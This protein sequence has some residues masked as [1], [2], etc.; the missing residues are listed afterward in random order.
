MTMW[1]IQSN[2]VSQL[3]GTFI[4][5]HGYQIGSFNIK[6]KPSQHWICKKPAQEKLHLLKSQEYIYMLVKDCRHFN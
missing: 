5:K 1:T 2:T 6:K 4:G 3:S